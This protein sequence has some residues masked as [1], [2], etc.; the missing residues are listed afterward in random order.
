LLRVK[1]PHDV[2]FVATTIQQE[3]EGAA[4]EGGRVT[5]AVAA[6]AINSYSKD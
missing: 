2:G 5:A 1:L 6:V 4:K 3:L